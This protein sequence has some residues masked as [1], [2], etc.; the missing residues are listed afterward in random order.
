M[1]RRVA[2][3]AGLA[4]L[5]IA[6]FAP[7]VVSGQDPTEAELRRLADA[8][9]QAW[10][11]GDAKAVAG[12]HT[13]EAIRIGPDG[14][15][16]VGRAAIEKAVSEELTGP[17]RGTKFG[18]TQ[19]QTTR[20]GQDVYVSEGTFQFSGGMPPAGS[21]TRGRY[22]NTIVRVSGRWLIAS[23]AATAAPRAPAK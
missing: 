7:G 6:L 1:T 5:M 16:A 10:A 15:V 8:Y 11:K 20:A 2:R 12:L 22:L 13:T 21:A 3:V 18:M 23:H 19:G 17:Y 4:V 9:A 14:K